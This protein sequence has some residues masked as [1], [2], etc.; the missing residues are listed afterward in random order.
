MAEKGLTIFFTQV[1]RDN[2]FHADMHPGNVFV[3]TLNPRSQPR[4]IA[5]DC[6]IMGEVVEARPND[7][8]TYATCGHGQRLYAT[9]S[10]RASS[11]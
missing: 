5:L 7:R 8:G 9:D 10:N 2:F 6:A 11:S 4:Y 3:E 1:F